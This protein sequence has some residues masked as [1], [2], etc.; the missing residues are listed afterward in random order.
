MRNQLEF[1]KN[2][3]AV[4][5]QSNYLQ[6]LYR[7]ARNPLTRY[8]LGEKQVFKTL[9][10]KG[11][12]GDLKLFQ[13]LKSHILNKQCLILRT[14]CEVLHCNAV[15]CHAV[16]TSVHETPPSLAD[17][18]TH[19]EQA[20]Q[21][22]TYQCCHLVNSSASV[23]GPPGSESGTFAHLF[24]QPTAVCQLFFLMTG[25]QKN[26]STHTNKKHRH[27]KL[28]TTE[29]WKTSDPLRLGKSFGSSSCSQLSK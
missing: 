26:E 25:I 10:F 2:L 27:H 8:L 4:N 20:L 3:F 24:K 11:I 13:P 28:N 21:G 9:I 14:S 22:I 29:R 18:Y 12:C 7:M 6:I 1:V 23:P 17:Q 19:W 16:C 15:S 5:I